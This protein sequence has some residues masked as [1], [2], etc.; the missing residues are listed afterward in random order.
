MDIDTDVGPLVHAVDAELADIGNTLLLKYYARHLII[1]LTLFQFIIDLAKQIAHLT[2]ELQ[3][4]K[5]LNKTMEI[6]LNEK[7]DMIRILKQHQ[8]VSNQIDKAGSGNLILTLLIST[9]TVNPNPY[10]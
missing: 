10:H 8:T 9:L 6:E 2:H 3:K 7:N 1:I 4:L 5:K